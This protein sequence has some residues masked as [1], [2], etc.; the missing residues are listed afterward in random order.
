MPTRSEWLALKLNAE[1][2]NDLFSNSQLQG[3]RIQFDTDYKNTI[4]DIIVFL[5]GLLVDWRKKRFQEAIEAAVEE[6]RS[7]TYK[8]GYIAGQQDK[9]PKDNSNE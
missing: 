9:D 6:A 5:C 8:D 3:M 2:P 4:I 7:E 1:Y